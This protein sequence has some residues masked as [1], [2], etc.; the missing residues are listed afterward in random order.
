MCFLLSRLILESNSSMSK[1]R[2][3]RKL[4]RRYSELARTN[5]VRFRHEWN[6]L[7]R[8][9]LYEIHNRV[10]CLCEGE[11]ISA[12]VHSTEES[13]FVEQKAERLGIFDLYYRADNLLVMCGEEVEHLVGAETRAV[14]S[15]ECSK[16]V[17][18]IYGNKRLYKLRKTPRKKK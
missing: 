6:N 16:A 13:L 5:D 18:I 14:L 17:S 11:Q 2:N 4:A 3:L 1:A 12:W 15:A 10:R 7:V 8:G 9:W